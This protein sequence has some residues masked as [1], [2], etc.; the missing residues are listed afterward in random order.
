MCIHI[1]I[2]INKIFNGGHRP[3]C[4]WGHHLVYRKVAVVEA[5][6]QRGALLPTIYI[7]TMTC[8]QII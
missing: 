7:E 2:Y 5:V 4:S 8:N 3:T 1:Y 6:V